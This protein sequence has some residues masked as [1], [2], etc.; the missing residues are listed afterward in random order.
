[1]RPVRHSRCGTHQ[2]A[3]LTL[4]IYDHFLDIKWLV[5]AKVL[6]QYWIVLD[7]YERGVLSVSLLTGRKRTSPNPFVVSRE[8]HCGRCG[9]SQVWEG[10]YKKRMAKF[11]KWFRRDYCSATCY[12]KAQESLERCCKLCGKQFLV[13]AGSKGVLFCGRHVFW[14]RNL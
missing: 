10:E 5:Q 12:A 3:N 4:D 9:K 13:K 1:M 8:W 14:W 11:F 7:F 2:L 6:E